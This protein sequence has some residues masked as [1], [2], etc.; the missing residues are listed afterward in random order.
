VSG[1]GGKPPD[2]ATLLRVI[3]ALPFG[4]PG[5]YP[6]WAVRGPYKALCA[7]VYKVHG[8]DVAFYRGLTLRTRLVLAAYLGTV[9]KGRRGE[10][11]AWEP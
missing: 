10:V 8:D 2:E 1:E 6:E 5:S 3:E 11:A 7:P 9:G 4:V